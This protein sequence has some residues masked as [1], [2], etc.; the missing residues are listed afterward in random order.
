MARHGTF[1]PAEGYRYGK[2]AQDLTAAKMQE[3]TEGPLGTAL[4]DRGAAS[5]RPAA[6]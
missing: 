6:S 1:N 5:A 2:A 4:A 3:N